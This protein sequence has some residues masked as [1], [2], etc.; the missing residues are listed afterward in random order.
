MVNIRSACV[1]SFGAH[2]RDCAGFARAVAQAVGVTLQGNA[3]EIADLLAAGTGGWEVL[4]DG[5]AAATAAQERLVIGGLRGDQQAHPD[6]HG[7]VV[8][9]VPGPLN[10]DRYP[11]AWWGSLAGQPGQDRTINWAW[12]A[13][14][15]DKVVYAAHDVTAS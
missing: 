1:K 13:D 10:R 3:N 8:V 4:A 15:R 6:L 11:T 5:P 2:Q 12:T 7:H 9:V 14:D